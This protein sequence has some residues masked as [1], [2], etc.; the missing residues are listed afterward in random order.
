MKQCQMNNS[1]K[2]MGKFIRRISL[3][4]SN[5]YNHTNL[6]LEKRSIQQNWSF[7][8]SPLDGPMDDHRTIQTEL[9]SNR[10]YDRPNKALRKH[11]KYNQFNGLV[12]NN[13]TSFISM[14]ENRSTKKTIYCN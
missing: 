8:S 5:N 12:R 13:C 9:F 2:Q 11:L 4:N 14:N 1:L 3:L 10:R 6:Y 7:Q